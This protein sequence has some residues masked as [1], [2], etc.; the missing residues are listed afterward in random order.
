MKL[1]HSMKLLL[2]SL[3]S[4]ATANNFAQTCLI[5]SALIA[6]YLMGVGAG[7]CV[8]TSGEV[9]V[10]NRLKRSESELIVFDVGSNK[11]QFLSMALEVLSCVPRQIHCF[12]PSKVAWASLCDT[13]TGSEGVTL[14]NIGLGRE[15]GERVLYSNAPGSGSA[16][17]TKRR[18]D[19][20]GISFSERETVCIDTLDNYCRSHGI[21]HVDLLKIDVEGHEMDVLNGAAELFRKNAIRFV[22]FEF[23]G[24]SID[25]RTFVQ[26]FWYFFSD[27]G[28]R[29][30]RITPGGFWFE[31]SD[32]REIYEQFRTTNF[33]AYS[34]L[35][36]RNLGRA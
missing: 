19:H 10:L 27:H 21:A 30:A 1:K 11:G 14:C 3:A 7:D 5:K 9:S 6:E 17:L 20:F 26:D 25:T 36:Q 23:G 15:T 2:A 13:A 16:S 28:M 29:I 4:Q 8:K 33:V 34:S 22:T 18:L 32:Y 31:L 35:G 12:E 24:C